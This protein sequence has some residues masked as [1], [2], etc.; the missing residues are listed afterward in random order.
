MT[1]PS[2]PN[3]VYRDLFT[4]IAA[5]R[6]MTGS[7]RVAVIDGLADALHS[8]LLRRRIEATDPDAVDLAEILGETIA[9][10]EDDCELRSRKSTAFGVI[11]A[12]IA[13]QI[14]GGSSPWPVIAGLLC[15]FIASMAMQGIA[16]G[17]EAAA[18]KRL[19]AALVDLRR[20]VAGARPETRVRVQAAPEATASLPASDAEGSVARSPPE[21]PA[22]ARSGRDKP[23]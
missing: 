21:E 19:N 14:R 16:A 18:L 13:A 1:N 15:A 23:P 6:A 12:A 10:L 5:L 7:S 11:A 22:S 9:R 3:L 2:S 20:L 4:R 8:L 17:R